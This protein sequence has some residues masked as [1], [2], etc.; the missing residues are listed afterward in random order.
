VE[1]AVKQNPQ[2]SD[3]EREKLLREL[4]EIVLAKNRRVDI[5]L[6]T[7]GQQSVQRYPFNASDA[8]ILLDERNLAER[9]KAAAHKK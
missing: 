2:L 1:D 5:T 8:L 3:T 7:T 9:K 6:S 4:P